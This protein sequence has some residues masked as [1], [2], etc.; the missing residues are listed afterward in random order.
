MLV[1]IFIHPFLAV[2]R[3]KIQDKLRKLFS[4]IHFRDLKKYLWCWYSNKTWVNT[5]LFV[6]KVCRIIIRM[7][8]L[9]N[10]WTSLPQYNRINYGVIKAR[11]VKVLL[12]KVGYLITW[13]NATKISTRN[14]VFCGNAVKDYSS[15][16]I[17]FKSTL[18]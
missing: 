18:Q 13:L 16:R 6:V 1:R 10:D 11:R 2:L 14:H 3:F 17:S 7:H 5:R 15:P 4:I 8:S 9:Y 12:A